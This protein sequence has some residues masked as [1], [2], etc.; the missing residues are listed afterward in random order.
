MPPSPLQPA[1]TDTVS[2]HELRSTIAATRGRLLDVLHARATT[3][4]TATAWVGPHRRRYEQDAAELLDAGRVLDR[5]LAD[6]LCALDAE[7]EASHP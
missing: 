7:I 6:L 3:L 2:A 5:A 1:R 4:S